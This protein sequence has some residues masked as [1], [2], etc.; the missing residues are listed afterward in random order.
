MHVTECQ[1][2]DLSIVKTKMVQVKY[3]RIKTYSL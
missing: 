1:H 3:L 2:V